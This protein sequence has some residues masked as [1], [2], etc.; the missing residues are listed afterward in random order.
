MKNLKAI[1]QRHDTSK[2]IFTLGQVMILLF[3]MIS[4]SYAVGSELEMVS[5][6]E[7]SLWDSALKGL[8][9]DRGT[10]KITTKVKGG[11]ETTATVAGSSGTSVGTVEGL[12]LN[13]GIGG[14]IASGLFWG[15]ISMK[16]AEWLSLQVLGLEDDQAKAVG[17]SVGAGV[18]A[19]FLTQGAIEQWYNAG[20]T[21]PAGYVVGGAIA[22]W[23]LYENYE[24]L[25]TESIIFTCS[26]WE[27][28]T[29]GE[30][31]EECNNAIFGC[32]EYQCKS[33]GKGCSLLNPGSTNELCTWVN[34]NDV[35]APE[36]RPWN[37]A[38][39]IETYKYTPDTTVSPP[40]RGVKII[41]RTGDECISA[42]TPL[43][44]GVTLN[45][46]ATCKIDT[47]RKSSYEDMTFYFGLDS[48]SR[49]NHTQIMSLPSLNASGVVLESGLELDMYVRCEDANG[50]SN[51]GNFVFHICVD[52]EA[53]ATAPLI[54]STSIPNKQPV[55]SG[56]NQTTI[57]AYI[58]E[59]ATCRWDHFDKD[60]EKMGSNFTCATT[61]IPKNSQIV[62]HCNSTLTGIKDRVENDYYFRCEDDDGNK[63]RESYKLTLVG[64]QPLY[65]DWAEPNGTIKDSISPARLKLEVKTSSGH[66][67]GN[68]F[69]YYKPKDSTSAYIQ[70]KY[71]PVA[72]TY[73]HT[74][75][76]VFAGSESGINYEYTIRCV[77]AGGNSDSTNISFSVETDINEPLVVRA[78][79]EEGYLKLITNEAGECV[80]NTIDDIGCEYEFE[81]GLAMQLVDED[82]HF[83]EWNTQET[84]YIKC[85]DAFE[86]PPAY[87]ACSGMGDVE[88]IIRPSEGEQI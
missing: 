4:I 31:C 22:L 62:Y 67:D 17:E 68:A 52:D 88:A 73:Q 9:G 3:G 77:D 32:S 81:D 1:L 78:Y 6:G 29:G 42:Y 40:D 12:N 25:H 50:N 61:P 66:Q 30:N 58:N 20:Y 76:L 71:E 39:D 38:L 33:L 56:I 43:K 36:I 64:T 83:V 51:L 11:G 53:D 2:K 23:Y 57:S 13:N 27:A 74:Q 70:F 54:T 10:G 85:K 46:P 37:A 8:F 75:D 34:R 15:G 82:E 44:F 60:F 59:Q 84:F 21:G 14:G 35:E 5:G 19:G 80:Y 79:R 24:E 87:N 63:N 45:E 65:I 55:A 41:S 48:L 47:S 72:M 49:Y 16:I 26:T 18:L 86:N 69:C 7:T 28:P